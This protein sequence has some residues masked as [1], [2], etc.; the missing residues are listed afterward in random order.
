MTDRELRE[1]R[2]KRINQKKK[3]TP[4]EAIERRE[5]RDEIYRAF[6]KRREALIGE[7]QPSFI[8]HENPFWIE[9]RYPQETERLLKE[10]ERLEEQTLAML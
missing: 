8:V 10:I 2:E 5:R 4:S 3:I 1:L 9:R 6:N 7:V